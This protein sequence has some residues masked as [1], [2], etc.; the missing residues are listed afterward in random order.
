MTRSGKLVVAWQ[1][2][3]SYYDRSWPGRPILST[4]RQLRMGVSP[5]F[6]PLVVDR[7]SPDGV[8][9]WE[10]R[11][12][13]DPVT[14]W[15]SSVYVTHPGAVVHVDGDGK[16][17]Q[18]Y[19]SGALSARY[20]SAG[21]T[22]AVAFET[23]DILVLAVRKQD[24]NNVAG[25]W[26]IQQ[27]A[28]G[29]SAFDI[30]VTRTGAVRLVFVDRGACC[31]LRITD[32]AFNSSGAGD[33]GD[34]I[35]RTIYTSPQFVGQGTQGLSVAVDSAGRTHVAYN[36]ADQQDCKSSPSSRCIY[37]FVG[38]MTLPANLANLAS[39]T[40]TDPKQAGQIVAGDLSY[41]PPVSMAINA[42]GTQVRVV[43]TDTR[44]RLI[45]TSGRPR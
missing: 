31:A 36:G 14:G 34:P 30:A 18:V 42:A 2:K 4:Q 22:Q 12:S 1:Q 8:Y 37:R 28:A 25:S 32:G 26:N 20:A 6:A 41:I 17:T 15:A 7:I 5:A 39:A 44:G 35:I 21:R 38:Y 27:V 43:Y 19:G 9:G 3:I 13:V 23:G 24:A 16:V 10:S 40:K 45:L 29:A 33:T 11:V